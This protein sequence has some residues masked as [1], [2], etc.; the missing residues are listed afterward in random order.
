MKHQLLKYTLGS[1]R[2]N[3][4]MTEISISFFCHGILNGKFHIT[5]VWEFGL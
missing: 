1:V 2:R 4:G 3:L 5:I